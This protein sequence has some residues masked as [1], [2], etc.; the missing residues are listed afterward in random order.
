[1]IT[2]AFAQTFESSVTHLGGGGGPWG[3]LPR[4]IPAPDT[5]SSS[6]GI[7]SR[8]VFADIIR[9]A[10]LIANPTPMTKAKWPQAPLPSQMLSRGPQSFWECREAVVWASALA[11]ALDHHTRGSA[12]AAAGDSLKLLR[13]QF[14]DRVCR[15]HSRNIRHLRASSEVM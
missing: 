11:L 4:G 5:A 10:F 2:C 12:L 9:I 6:A 7:N 1:M 8:I 13:S 15:H 14:A 3:P